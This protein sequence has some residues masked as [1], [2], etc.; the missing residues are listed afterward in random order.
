MQFDNKTFADKKRLRLEAL[1][2]IQEPLILETHGGEGKLFHHCYKNYDGVVFEKDESKADILACQR[3]TWRIYNS[4]S[5][6]CLRNG[7]ASD[8]KFNFIDIDPYGSAWSFIEAIFSSERLLADKLVVYDNDELRQKLQLRG[9]WNCTAMSEEVGQFGNDNL[10]KKYLEIC[11]QKIKKIASQKGY[12]LTRWA[13]Y[14]AGKLKQ[15]THYAALL[16]E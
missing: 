11:E 10:Y 16:E 2:L 6:S 9:G 5:E 12:S 3:P 1:K 8:L 4:D 13:G 14:Y 15:M 7:V